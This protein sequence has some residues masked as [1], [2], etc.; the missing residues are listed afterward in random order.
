MRAA[1]LTEFM[2][3]AGVL[4]ANSERDTHEYTNRTFRLQMNT[5]AQ[6]VSNTAM[7]STI[8]VE[9]DTH[10]ASYIVDEY[11]GPRAPLSNF[12]FYMGRLEEFFDDSIPLYLHSDVV[13][14]F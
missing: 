6:I 2:W 8:S 4:A 1:G 9:M 14:G 5:G 13:P 7:V 3:S 10:Y 11:D 12:R